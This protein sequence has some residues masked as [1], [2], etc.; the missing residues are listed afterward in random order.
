[1]KEINNYY[2]KKDKLL[3]LSLQNSL[4][5]DE[6]YERNNEFNEIIKKLNDELSK[7]KSDKLKIKNAS[8]KTKE[9]DSFLKLKITSQSTFNKMVSLLLDH[10]MVS[11]INNDKNKMKLD[12]FLSY[13]N[14]NNTKKLQPVLRENY[15]F[16]RGYDTSG[17]K[18]YK[19]SYQVNLY[20]CL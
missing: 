16:K 4:S 3:E 19:V 1:E 14:R 7:F 15:E 5:N 10:I 6:F 9:L 20:F 13:K 17:T 12:I 11:S 2:A 18:R 8:D